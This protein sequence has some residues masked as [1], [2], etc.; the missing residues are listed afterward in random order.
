M[1]NHWVVKAAQGTRSTDVCLTD[2]AA[3]VLAYRCVASLAGSGSLTMR[4][5]GMIA[6]HYARWHGNSATHPALMKHAVVA[7]AS[8]AGIRGLGIVVRTALPAV[9]S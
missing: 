9:A 7:F 3:T 2:D 1:D 6:L 4:P 8:R 5:G